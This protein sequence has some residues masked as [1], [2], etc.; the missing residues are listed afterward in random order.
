MRKT[1]FMRSFFLVLTF[2]L[3]IHFSNA[4]RFSVG[5][6]IGANLSQINGLPYSMPRGGWNI[7]AFVVYNPCPH[8]GFSA[9]L[10]LSS[11]GSRSKYIQKSGTTTESWDSYINMNY[12]NLPLLYNLYFGKETSMFRPKL[13]GGVS[14]GFLLS[15]KQSLVYSL[16]NNNTQ[17]NSSSDKNNCGEF[18]KIDIGGIAGGGFV[19]KMEENVQLNFDVRYLY[20]FQDIRSQRSIYTGSLHNNNISFLL[21]IAYFLK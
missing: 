10:L 4:Q 11:N 9:D 1:L 17:I 15:S 16:E 7:G 20:G 18:K 3:F 19:F 14:T 21:G 8:T 13:F 6:R 5:P 2:S 12:L